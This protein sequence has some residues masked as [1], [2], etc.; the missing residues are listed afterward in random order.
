MSYSFL[1]SAMSMVYLPFAWIGMNL[2]SSKFNVAIFLSGHPRE[3][4]WSLKLS[5]FFDGSRNAEL[6]VRTKAC[7]FILDVL[8]L[9]H[10][11]RRYVCTRQVI[12]H[13]LHL[14]DDCVLSNYCAEIFFPLPIN[15][16]DNAF[17]VLHRNKHTTALVCRVFIFRMHLFTPGRVV[18]MRAKR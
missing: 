8:L 2:L 13:M 12:Q 4:S 3:M 11:H 1:A 5:A 9:V 18:V 14:V 17:A 6:S 7:F 16:H 10:S 15:L